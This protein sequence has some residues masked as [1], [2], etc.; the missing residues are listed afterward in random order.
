M[1]RLQIVFSD[2]IVLW[3]VC[4]LW[5]RRRF[6]KGLA[7]ILVLS[8]LSKHAPIAFVAASIL[9]LNVSHYFIY[10]VD[11]CL[12]LS[13]VAVA[14]DCPGNESLVMHLLQLV[15]DL[16][17]TPISNPTSQHAAFPF[18]QQHSS[19]YPLSTLLKCSNA[20]SL[21]SRTC[22]MSFSLS[23]SF[24]TFTLLSITSCS[25]KPLSGQEYKWNPVQLTS[26]IFNI[27][28]TPAIAALAGGKTSAAD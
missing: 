16:A 20:S 22:P 13:L 12:N 24:L 17:E 2:S 9:T 27:S 8:T 28:M 19:S 15:A 5:P 11:A 14:R 18:R 4:A 3:R 25:W 7:V 6:V 21:S 23:N 10:F 1:E 26:T